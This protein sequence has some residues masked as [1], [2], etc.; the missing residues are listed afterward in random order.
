M[1]LNTQNWSILLHQQLQRHRHRACVVLCGDASW[2]WQH[3]RALIPEQQ[4]GLIVGEPTADSPLSSLPQARPMAASALKHQLGQETDF[5]IFDAE[6][7]FDADALGIVIGMIRAGGCC[8]LCLPPKAAFLSQP[9]PAMRPYLNAPLSLDDTLKG[10][11]AYLWQSLQNRAL[12]L[13]PERP[14]PDLSNWM[15]ATPQPREPLPTAD[16]QR[17]IEAIHHLAFGHRKRPVV[18]T[19]D[20]GRGKS[21]TLGL[22]CLRL[23]AEGKQHITLTAARRAQLESAF[24]AIET[25]LQSTGHSALSLVEKHP[26]PKGTTGLVVLSLENQRLT[27]KFQAPDALLAAPA[28]LATDVLMI[29]E[30][31]HLPLPMLQALLHKHPRVLLSTTQQGYEGSGRGFSLK[32][33]QFLEQHFPNWKAISLNQPIRW[34]RQDPLENTLNRL[35]G[36]QSDSKTN[37]TDANETVTV[38][39][40]AQHTFYA[41]APLDTLIESPEQPSLFAL[42]Q[43]LSQAHYQTRPNDLMQLLEVPNQQLWVAKADEQLI[44]VLRALTEGDLPPLVSQQR[45]QGH[46]FPQ[47][48]AKN[49]HQPEWRGLKTLRIQRLAV[50]PEWQNQGVGSQLLKH[51]MMAQQAANQTAPTLDALTTSF[52]A[53][54]GLVKFWGAAGF[55]PVHL[56]I[57]KNKASGLHSVSMIAPL[58]SSARTLTE[59]SDFGRQFAWQLTDAFQHLDSALVVELICLLQPASSQPTDF[60]TGYLDDQPFEAVSWA[61]REWTLSH[62]DC[63]K[64]LGPSCPLGMGDFWCRK[65]LQ[66][67][68]WS[69]LPVN[70]KALEMQFKK[71][72]T[73]V[74]FP[75]EASFH[76]KLLS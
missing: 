6:W 47:L 34:N 30:A 7:G 55:V 28:P 61:L 17:A 19:A 73:A 59:Q 51:F 72:L 33:S 76:P 15:E 36:F 38:S 66:N 40:K 32:L 75:P 44:G 21:Y 63:L 20:R 48:L 69:S 35:L 52:G 26:Y 14:L 22:A 3:L 27:V 12:W 37:P 16:Q 57:Q 4:T 53:S 31:A 64:H 13:F 54:P 39:P 41:I 29:D 9:N 65:V 18:L 10:F 23:L 67:H 74:L 56:G 1:T 68:P 58:S 5:A 24:L 71:A 45:Q 25:D 62:P 43:L 49:S 50:D 60:P 70:R 8:Y 42:F 11:Q 46:L 2:R